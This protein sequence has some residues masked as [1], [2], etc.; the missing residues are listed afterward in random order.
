LHISKK[1]EATVASGNRMRVAR[2]RKK[3]EKGGIADHAKH[4][5]TGIVYILSIGTV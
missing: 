4:I 3:K 5:Y 1:S 2:K